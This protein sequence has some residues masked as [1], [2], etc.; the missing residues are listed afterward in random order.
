MMWDLRGNDTAYNRPRS[1][2]PRFPVPSPGI[3]TMRELHQSRD[4]FPRP[5]E[6]L[7]LPNGSDPRS[8]A[9]NMYTRARSPSR[10]RGQP[11]PIPH[12]TRPPP[13]PH[14]SLPGP[15]HP[16]MSQPSRPPPRPPPMPI[17]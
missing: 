3:P 15:A 1:P 12:A 10:T 8:A 14:V 5:F 9:P 4:A 16:L 7:G 13:S 6:P 11:P 17:P 2:N